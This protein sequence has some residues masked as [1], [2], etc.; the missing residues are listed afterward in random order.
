MGVFQ[1]TVPDS[2]R[3]AQSTHAHHIARQDKHLRL[4]TISIVLSFF[5]V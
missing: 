3:S 1:P 4:K 5:F 2:N